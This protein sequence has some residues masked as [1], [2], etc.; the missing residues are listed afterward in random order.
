MLYGISLAPKILRWLPDF[1][2]I[3][4]PLFEVI[5]TLTHV[6]TEQFLKN[7]REF[8]LLTDIPCP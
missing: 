6:L 7:H 2:K 4:A 3:G 1:C 8:H 5:S